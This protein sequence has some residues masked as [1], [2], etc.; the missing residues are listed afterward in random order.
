MLTAISRIRT[1]SS[2]CRQYLS[3]S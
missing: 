2:W 3:R 1:T